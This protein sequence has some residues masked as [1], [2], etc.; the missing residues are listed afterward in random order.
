MTLTQRE[1]DEIRAIRGEWLPD[2]CTI[3]R[4]VLIAPEFEEPADVAANVPVRVKE[5]F[6]LFKDLADQFQ[7]QNAHT[8]T[9]EY[10]QELKVQDQV[11]VTTLND[12]LFKVIGVADNTSYL[13]GVMVLA[14][15]LS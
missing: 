6:S 14:D 12:Q 7:S 15:R 11:I 3:R 1:L 2:R 10:D 8:L 5:G 9:F 4:K 13:T